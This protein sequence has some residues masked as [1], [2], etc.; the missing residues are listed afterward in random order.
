MRTDV[1]LDVAAGVQSARAEGQLRTF[2]EDEMDEE[3]ETVESVMAAAE[4][5]AGRVSVPDLRD[6]APSKPAAAR[7]RARASRAAS[8]GQSG[9]AA[10]SRAR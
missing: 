7:H 4:V 5:T 1:P 10:W 9:N 3:P 6:G 2:M 8:A